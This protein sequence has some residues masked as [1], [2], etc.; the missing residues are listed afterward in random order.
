L[1]TGKTCNGKLEPGVTEKWLIWHKL[2]AETVA[3]LAN[4]TASSFI[5]VANLRNKVLSAMRE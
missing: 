3:G 4:Y 2:G 5:L 1:L